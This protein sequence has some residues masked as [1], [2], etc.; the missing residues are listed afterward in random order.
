MASTAADGCASRR[1]ATRDEGR[2]VGQP[3]REL[4]VNRGG[5]SQKRTIKKLRKYDWH[6]Y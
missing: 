4:E 5:W 1:R 3:A 2:V 6:R